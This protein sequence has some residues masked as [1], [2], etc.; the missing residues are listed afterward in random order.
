MKFFIT[1]LLVAIFVA[2]AM[3]ATNTHVEQ[4]PIVVS[5]PKGTPS[6]EME[7]LKAAILK[8]GGKITHEYNLFM[9][10]AAKVP[11]DFISTIKTMGEDH[12]VNVE[13]DQVMSINDDHNGGP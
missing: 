4:K 2:L 13:D 10:L 5:Y 8:V 11:A 9:G 6:S 12:G 1:T 7:E 3:A